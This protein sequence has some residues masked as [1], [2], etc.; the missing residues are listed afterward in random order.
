MPG[1]P[2]Y[3]LLT[4]A[5]FRRSCP[6]D[7]NKN[8]EKE[9]YVEWHKMSYR[10]PWR[11]PVPDTKGFIELRHKNAQYWITEADLSK[12]L[13]VDHVIIN[14]AL[15]DAEAINTVS[16]ENCTDLEILS[17]WKFVS[18]R[19]LDI[20]AV[21]VIGYAKNASAMTLFRKWLSAKEEEL[22]NHEQAFLKDFYEDDLGNPQLYPSFIVFAD[23]LG[24]SSIIK[25]TTDE[26][27]QLQLLK[28]IK[29]AY[30]SADE[31]L[32]E[33]GEFRTSYLRYFTDCIIFL[34]PAISNGED[35]YWESSFGNTIP[36]IMWW[37]AR[38][39]FQGYFIRGGIDFGSIFV[40]DKTIFG[41]PLLNAVDLE[42]SANFPR[43]ILSEDLLYVI[44]KQMSFYAESAETPHQNELLLDEDG[45]VFINYLQTFSDDPQHVSEWLIQHKKNIERRRSL[46]PEESKAKVSP[47]YDWLE[48]YHNWYCDQWSEEVV[49]YKTVKFDGESGKYTD[50][51]PFIEGLV[52]R[53]EDTE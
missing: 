45:K 11:Y 41:E 14:Q 20:E 4:R 29:S 1:G 17:E 48:K 9:Y 28:E 21:Y 27:E 19:H 51:R 36:N 53:E 5:S 24:F 7:R 39:A 15:I 30:D 18:L 43:I 3:A 2:D 50:I 32:S 44:G 34:T 47:K 38:M 16:S 37:Q 40:S 31:L 13:N 12:L 10:I 8:G 6:H 25:D 35:T 46:V 49:D 33:D 22:R 23:L 26:G 42:K 52:K